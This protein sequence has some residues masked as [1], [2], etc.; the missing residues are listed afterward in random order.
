MLY[1]VRTDTLKKLKLNTEASYQ[2]IHTIRCPDSRVMGLW[3]IVIMKCIIISSWLNLYSTLH[4]TLSLSHSYVI[5]YVSP[6]FRRASFIVLD[7]DPSCLYFVRIARSSPTGIDEP[8]TLKSLTGESPLF[9]KTLYFGSASCAW[10]L[11]LGRSFN[12]PGCV[13]PKR[14]TSQSQESL[15]LIPCSNVRSMFSQAA[16]HARD[17]IVK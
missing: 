4:S 3:K 11:R 12:F 9:G 7:P 15:C 13:S 1:Y 16:R 14:K 17:M 8:S 2:A 6:T 5:T 10:Y